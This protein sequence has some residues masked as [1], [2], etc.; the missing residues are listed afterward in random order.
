MTAL[1]DELKTRARLRLNAA[2]REDADSDGIRLRHCLNQVAREVGF[3]HWEHARAVLG[4]LATREDDMGTFWHAP[5]TG[6][7]LNLWLARYEQARAALEAD[8]AAFLLPY[9]RQF[10]VVQGHFIEALGVDANHPAW[11]ETAHDLVAAYGGSAWL[12]LA[13]Q[14]LRAPR[15]SFDS[16]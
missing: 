12:E 15:S 1:L 4:G 8:P 13:G 2:R 5:R 9:R 3:A 7:L 10:M 14:R 11:A 6:I 16:S